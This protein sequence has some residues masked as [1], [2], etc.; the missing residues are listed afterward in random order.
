MIRTHGTRWLAAALLAQAAGCVWLAAEEA[1]APEPEPEP[2]TPPAPAHGCAHESDPACGAGRAC[3]P[4]LDR[5]VQTATRRELERS[6]TRLPD[7]AS[8]SL[9][10]CTGCAAGLCRDDACVSGLCWDGL[11][12]GVCAADAVCPAETTCASVEV[13]PHD[14]PGLFLD[15]CRP[16]GTGAGLCGG[17]GDGCAEGETCRLYLDH[18]PGDTAEYRRASGLCGPPQGT[19]PWL[20]ACNPPAGPGHEGCEGGFCAVFCGEATDPRPLCRTSWCTGPCG[21]DAECPFPMWCHAMNSDEYERIEPPFLGR[22]DLSYACADARDCGEGETCG[23]LASE[24]TL[25]SECVAVGAGGGLGAPCA[26][27]DDCASG[28]CAPLAAGGVCTTPCIAE[29]A[30]TPCDELVPGTTCKPVEATFGGVGRVVT[31]CMP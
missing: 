31:A 1:P 26:A 13:D 7:G 24:G 18:S 29:Q 25:V 9:A 27:G 17:P 11:C 3:V 2:G 6:C 30:H 28:L 21:S 16:S 20:S 5:I 22:C 19:L 10:R 12:V 15:A 4:R 23:L 8:P 14:Q